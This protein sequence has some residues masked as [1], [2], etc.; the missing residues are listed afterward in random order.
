[1]PVSN[2]RL[3]SVMC[4]DREWVDCL[5]ETI[6]IYVERCLLLVGINIDWL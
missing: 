2:A 5:T 1:M 3:V 6:A 4:G